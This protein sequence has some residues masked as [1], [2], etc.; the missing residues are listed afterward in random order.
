VFVVNYRRADF[1]SR[2]KLR[3]VLAGVVAG[4]LPAILWMLTDIAAGVFNLPQSSLLLWWLFVIGSFALALIPLT[5]A[6]AIMR[7]RVIPISL[8]IRL[9]VQYLLAKNAL[10]T[11][12]ALPIMGLAL[13]ILLHPNRTLPEILFR[14]TVYFYLLT[15]VAVTMGLVYRKRLSKW[16][17][18]K[19]FQETYN[20][21]M[22]L[23]RAIDEMKRL[24][25]MIDTSRQVGE[26]LESTLHPKQIYLFYRNEGERD[27]LLGYATGGVL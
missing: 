18:R 15:L 17:D 26:Q 3:V 11:L 4:L 23:R 20:Q 19:F 1:T 16:V 13:T 6:Y 24:D 7:H 9:S 14:N 12:L 21:E 8:I 5:F 25:S 27:F 2:R 10:R 22:I